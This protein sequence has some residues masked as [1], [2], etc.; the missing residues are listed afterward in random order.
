MNHIAK[1]PEPPYYAVGKITPRTGR[2]SDSAKKNGTGVTK[3]E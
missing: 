2:H 1:T 3:L